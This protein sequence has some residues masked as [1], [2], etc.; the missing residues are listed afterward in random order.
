[1]P[2]TGLAVLIAA[3]ASCTESGEDRRSSSVPAPK[4]DE[5]LIPAPLAPVPGLIDRRAQAPLA[6]LFEKANPDHDDA[7]SSESFSQAAG[8][9]LLR[10]AEALKKHGEWE[11]IE[12]GAGPLVDAGYRGSP[13]RPDAKE[14]FRDGAISVSRWRLP[15][16]GEGSGSGGFPGIEGFKQSF[17]ELVTSLDAGRAGEI[18]AKFKVIRVDL[19]PA[20]ARTLVYADL[21]A[22]HPDHHIQQTAAWDCFWSSA[23]SGSSPLLAGI[24]VQDFEEITYAG[25]ESPAFADGTES[26]LGENASFREQLIYGADHWYGSL[27]AAFGIHQG[28]QGLSIGDADGDGLDDLLVCQP[29]GLLNRLYLQNPDG[30]LRDATQAA[31]LDW[32]DSARSALFL[33]LDNDGDQDL[34]ITLGY[35][36]GLFENDG[37][38]VFHLFSTVEIYSW[39]TSLAAAD[40]DNDGDLDIFVCGYN[41]RG[42]TAPGDI[43]ANPVPYHDA[44][45]GARNFLLENKGDLIF[46]DVT[47]SSGLNVNN[48]RFSFAASWEDYD[49]DGD[50]DLYVANDFGRNNLYHNEYAETGVPRFRDVA[51]EAGVEDIAAGMSVSWGDYNRD[52]WIDLYVSNMFSSAG[53]RVTYQRQFKPG[54]DAGLRQD[55]Q[56]H[57]RG[58]TLF[59]NSGDGTFKD[60][61]TEASVTMGRWAWASHFVD[62]NNDG[63]QDLYVAN[64]FYTTPDTGDL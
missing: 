55:I 7:W 58:N 37:T 53:N 11:S 45:N 5:A 32:L 59:E 44:N 22:V 4:E 16:A 39:P 35:S 27:D 13:L 62:I 23:S 38:G 41:P 24:V 50:Q 25:G 43:F 17:D 18:R 40:Y 61:S 28:N 51:A 48:R 52:G 57:A 1:M 60:V 33:D 6:G 8:N 64:G 3:V 19:N 47:E 14:I 34:V 46:E 49:N 26:L 54:A 9:Q 12:G 2:A 21:A 20:G 42:E 31:G 29:A 10:I 36:L 30:S 63:W 15:A 56:R